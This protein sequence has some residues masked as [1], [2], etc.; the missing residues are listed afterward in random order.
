MEWRSLARRMKRWHSRRKGPTSRAFGDPREHKVAVGR[1]L[2][3][4]S[5]QLAYRH[6]GYR[7]RTLTVGNKYSKNTTEG[8]NY[9]PYMATVVQ[10]PS[11]S[12]DYRNVIVGHKGLQL[13][14]WLAQRLDPKIETY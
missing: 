8:N 14:D 6:S 9:Q 10:E 11:L 1:H 12:I 3:D 2:R 13:G 4:M 5:Q 7:Q